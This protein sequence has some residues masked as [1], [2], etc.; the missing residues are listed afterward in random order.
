MSL[1]TLAIQKAIFF[2][3]S[4]SGVNPLNF[5]RFAFIGINCTIFDF[6]KVNREKV[7]QA[8]LFEDSC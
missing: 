2:N 6:L 4:R 1:I 3:G 7:H 8:N 5:V